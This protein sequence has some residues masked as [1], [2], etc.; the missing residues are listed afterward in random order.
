MSLSKYFD[1]VRDP[2]DFLNKNK[3]YNDNKLLTL[4]D[5]HIED[6]E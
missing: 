2:S 1:Y 6:W 3:Q 5:L 4:F